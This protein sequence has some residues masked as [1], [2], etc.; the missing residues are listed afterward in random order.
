MAFENIKKS[1]SKVFALKSVIHLVSSG[2]LINLYYLAITD[3][4]G[5]D[6]VEEVLHFTGMGAINLLLLSLMITP[7][8]QRFKWH[9]L[10]KIRRLV[11][12]YSFTYVLCHMLSFLAFEVQ[13]D[14]S[15]FIDEIVERP[16][17]TVGMAGFVLLTLLAITSTSAIKRSM[18]K[19]WQQLHYWV[20]LAAI[21]AVIHFYLSVKSEI[22]EPSVYLLCVVVLLSFR[23]QKILRWLKGN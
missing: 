20:Y 13:F 15:L 12:L 23:K 19:R 11:G 14:G 22:I 7:V 21:L 6:P 9:W 3:Q 17:I 1:L 4:L 18:G 16:Y 8:I 2:L 10:L 5:G